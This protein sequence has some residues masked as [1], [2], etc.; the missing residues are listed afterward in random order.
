MYITFISGT[1]SQL[2]MHRGISMLMIITGKCH[3]SSLIIS[4]FKFFEIGNPCNMIGSIGVS[5][6]QIAPLFALNRI[7]FPIQLGS[8]TKKRNQFPFNRNQ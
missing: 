1:T 8:F 2:L 3:H 7:F 5:Y 6:S 4:I